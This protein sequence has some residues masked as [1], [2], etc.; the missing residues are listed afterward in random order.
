M[1]GVSKTIIVSGQIN[2]LAN[3]DGDAKIKLQSGLKRFMWYSN[4]MQT[5]YVRK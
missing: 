4:S 5:H 2:L 3:P 1:D